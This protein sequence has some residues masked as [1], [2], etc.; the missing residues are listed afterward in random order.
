MS[1]L[2]PISRR[3]ALRLLGAG[4]ATL[5]LADLAGCDRGGARQPNILVILTDDVR[6]DAMGC[7]GDKRLETPNLDKLAADGVRFSNAFVTTSLCSPSRASLL[8]GC[9]AH[10]HGVRDNFSRDPEQACPSFAEVLQ[11]SGYETGYV[12]KWHMLQSGTPRAG[13]DHWVSFTGQGE[14]FRN[15]LNVDGKWNLVINYVTDEL[16]D[17]AVRFIE[18]ER[19]KPFLL[20]LGHKA[21]H[22]PFVPAQRH[23]QRYAGADLT[24]HGGHGGAGLSAKP[25]W[26]GRGADAVTPED[27]RNYHRCLLS[28]D[29]S[30]GRLVET[31]KKRSL[32]DDTLII[33][34]SDNGLMLGEHGGL[35]DKRAAYEP[36]IRVP[37]VVRHPKLAPRG[38]VNEEMVLGIDLL[39]AL[40]E[41]AGVPAPAGVQGRSWLPLLKGSTGRD[42]FLYEYFREEGPVPTC[43]AVRSRDWKLITFPE[44]PALPS[45]LYD[46]RN[47]P[48]ENTN[49]AGRP[50]HVAVQQQLS[51]RLAAL[52]Q[53]TGYRR[54][55]A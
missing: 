7:A 23:A 50:E 54:P 45:E 42:D 28:V 1:P 16:T 18:R 41:A 55:T 38:K 33:Y 14:Y 22:A 17:H 31:L 25:D 4:A 35:R 36:S 26:G 32:L 5:A 34:T 27:L 3:D 24:P 46:L 19:T 51:A 48:D 10:K 15:T 8:T 49:L 53:E 52:M 30:V 20:V 12:G 47:D 2:P 40:C 9:Y 13:F 37:M 29:E 21:A 39:P 43:L 11:K 44:D 6:H